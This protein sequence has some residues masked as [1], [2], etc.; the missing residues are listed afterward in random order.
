[1]MRNEK[2]GKQIF[3]LGSNLNQLTWAYVFFV[4]IW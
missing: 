3:D 4:A 1:M 2:N